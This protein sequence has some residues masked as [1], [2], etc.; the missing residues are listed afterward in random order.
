MFV[1]ILCFLSTAQLCVILLYHGKVDLMGLKPD[2][3]DHGW[4]I[5]EAGKAEASWP[6][7][8]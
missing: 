8:Q 5:H 2:P 6:E 4:I 1:C 3:Q 7:P